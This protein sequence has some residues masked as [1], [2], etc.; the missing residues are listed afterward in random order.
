MLT[1][2]PPEITH[3]TM[4]SCF[5]KSEFGEGGYVGNAQS[6]PLF[7]TSTSM[8][9]CTLVE[10]GQRSANLQSELTYLKPFGRNRDLHTIAN[11]AIFG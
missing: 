9:I 5:P 4:G 1:A 6:K 11:L 8:K 3:L 2:R 7:P 10:K